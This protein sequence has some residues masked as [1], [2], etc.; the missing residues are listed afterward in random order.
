MAAGRGC[1]ETARLRIFEPERVPGLRM[2]HLVVAVLKWLFAAVAVALW[3]G[4]GVMG[5]PARWPMVGMGLIF[6]SIGGGLIA[7]GLW[8]HRLE[9][10]LLASGRRVM[11]QFQAVELNT[12]ISVSRGHPRGHPFR[13]VARWHDAEGQRLLVFRSRNLWFDPSEFIPHGPILVYM[14]PARPSRH[15]MDLSFLPVVQ[16]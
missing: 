1:G 10:T 3:I 11:A 16:G 14:D 2:D 5:E 6:G 8:S 15:L 9:A 13:I 7:Y 12:S 4:A